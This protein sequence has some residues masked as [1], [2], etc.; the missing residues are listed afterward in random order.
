[1]RRTLSTSV[2]G[3]GALRSRETQASEE[4]RRNDQEK[5]EAHTAPAHLELATV[6]VLGTR[7]ETVS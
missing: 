4:H 5:N 3:L 1:M 7:Y 2:P 6:G